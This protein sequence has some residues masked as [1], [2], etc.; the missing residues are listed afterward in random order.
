[1]IKLSIAKPKEKIMEAFDEIKSVNPSVVF[2][3]ASPSIIR[4]DTSKQQ[5]MKFAADVPLFGCST[6]GEIS[7]DGF[8]SEGI[9]AIAVRFENTE[10]KI[11]KHR[12]NGTENSFAIGEK[13]ALDL[14][15]D[16]LRGIILLGPGTNIN[17]SAIIEGMRSKLSSDIMLSGGLAADGWD[18][19]ETYT[20]CDGDI[21]SDTAIALG[22]YGD[23]VV[24]SCGSNGGWR[25]FGPARRVTK[26]V[27]NVLHEL[28]GKPALQLYKHYL[29]DKAKLLPG[30]G[31]SYPFAIL[32]NDRSTT[33][34]I[35]SA[36]DINHNE[37]TLILA[38]DI[39][40]GCQVC[41]MHADSDALAE[42]AAQAASEALRTHKGNDDNGFAL[43]VSC[44]GRR[45]V[46]G[47]D[48]D[49]EI[50]RAID[51]FPTDTAIGGFYSYGEICS[52]TGTGRTELHNQ[53][54]TITY[55]T[56]KTH[57]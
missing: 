33:G 10:I 7:N 34:L 15:T 23:D 54:M 16:Q 8:S 5:I 21:Y 9:S 25:P 39:P 36:L 41:L 38:G 45:D 3:F 26:S 17:G 22:L 44:M 48:V 29:G 37:E 18:F 20:F 4:D 40:Q 46:M 53:T 2:M 24:I 35:R 1:M 52:Y 50:E 31:I 30:S 6:A 42:G 43:L 57:K 14:K 49:E 47:I 27:G 55:I 12:L 32:R 56:E 28:D 13:L 11:A 19:N 51:V